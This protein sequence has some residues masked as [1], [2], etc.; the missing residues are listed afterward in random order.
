MKR[1]RILTVCGSGTVSSTMIAQ[2][3]K[4]ALREKGYEAD[5]LEVNS[6]QVANKLSSSHFD[7]VCYASPI[8]GEYGIPCINGIG[9]LT[10]MDEEGVIEAVL[11]VGEKL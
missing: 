2:K 3:L 4:D 8:H 10:G 6:S 5:C 1:I 11:K 9:L 7:C